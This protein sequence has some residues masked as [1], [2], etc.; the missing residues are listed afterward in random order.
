MV[1]G[2]I[3]LGL[4]AQCSITTALDAASLCDE[5]IDSGNTCMSCGYCTPSR[6][7]EGHALPLIGLKS[8]YLNL[9][10]VS[11]LSLD[12]W[13]FEFGNGAYLYW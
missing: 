5:R 8:S 9:Y 4:A 12:P 3:S 11:S 10:L 6:R 1:Y 7:A 2:G 13:V